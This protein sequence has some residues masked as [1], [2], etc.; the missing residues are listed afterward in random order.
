MMDWMKFGRDVKAA[1]T[2]ANLSLREAAALVGLDHTLWHR[3]EHAR[4]LTNVLA[5]LLICRWMEVDPF[6]YLN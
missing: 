4:P 6:G 3:T 1:R 2:A 5:Y